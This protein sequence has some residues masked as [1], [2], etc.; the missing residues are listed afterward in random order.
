MHTVIVGTGT[1]GTAAAFLLAANQQ[2]VTLLGRSADKVAALR[3]SRRH[4]QLGD[5]ALPAEIGLTADPQILSQAD[6]VLWAVPTQHS[7]AW[8]QQLVPYLPPLV[9]LVSLAKGFEVGTLQTP[10]ELLVAIFG[11]RPCAVLSGPS[12]AVEI[13]AGKPVC[14]VAAGPE[15]V[16]SV[17]RER[18]HGPRCRI[19][20]SNDRIGVEIGGALKNVVAIAAGICDG[21]EVGDNLKA[22]LITRGLAEMR[23]LGRALGAQD[24]TFSGMAGIGDLLTTCY[25]PHGR[26][27]ALGKVIASGV[28]PLMF[29]R[30][31]QTVAEGAATSRAAVELAQRYGVDLPIAAQV[32]AIIW[33][34]TPVRTAMDALFARSPKEEDA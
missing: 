17:L 30:Q 4:P 32:C 3:D 5:V 26:N 1:W 27:R 22:A 11:P 34:Q 2:P 6:L 7:R 23:R 25:A 31:Q 15:A 18:L 8:A 14:L 19:Y 10:C 12:H 16:T 21:L 24:A 20:T 29:L 28:N 33:Q 9:P 13:V